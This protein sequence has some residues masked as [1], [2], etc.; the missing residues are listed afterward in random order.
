MSAEPCHL[1]RLPTELRLHIYDYALCDAEAITISSGEVIDY[2]FG[3]YPDDGCAE[4]SIGRRHKSIPGLP[5]NHVPIIRRH[6]DQS[7]LS[8]TSPAVVLPPGSASLSSPA[9]SFTDSAYASATSLASSSQTSTEAPDA[10]TDSSWDAIPLSTPLSLLATCRTI[11]AELQSHLQFQKTT[12]AQ[13]GPA[14]YVSYPTGLLVLKALCSH[15]LAHARAVYIAGAYHVSAPIQPPGNESALS[16]RLARLDGAQ[17]SYS[18]HA[19]SANDPILS[20]RPCHFH[21]PTPEATAALASTVRTLLGPHPHPTL[22]KL[23][24]RIYYP[25]EHSYR[26]VWGDDSSPIVVA[27][28]N[29]WG[30]NIETE[31]WRGR[32]GTG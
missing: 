28:Q 1:L 4:E 29:T 22:Q 21:V 20:R 15:L 3:V 14:L 7:L 6:Y 31:V 8:I 10:N 5:A 18:R 30:G 13:Y 27:L 12:T 11:N 26:Y 23:Q 32:W 16:R 17:D 2:G 25:S 24:L 19:T 9:E